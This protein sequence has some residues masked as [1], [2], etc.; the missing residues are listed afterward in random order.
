MSNEEPNVELDNNDQVVEKKETTKNE[1]TPKSKELNQPKKRKKGPKPIYVNT[2]QA[3]YPIIQEALSGIGYKFTDDDFK[4]NLFW[5]NQNGSI[6]TALNSCL[7]NSIIIF[8]V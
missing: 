1:N 4:A 6:D 2:T 5:I 3:Y 7:G 8:L